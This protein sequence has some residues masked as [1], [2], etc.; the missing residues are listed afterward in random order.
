MVKTIGFCPVMEL[1]K[2]SIHSVCSLLNK[3][4]R[5][6]RHLLLFSVF[7]F[8]LINHIVTQLSLSILHFLVSLLHYLMEDPFV[9]KNLWFGLCST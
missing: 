1:G 4:L 8:Q 2:G 3:Q 7:M 6:F 9:I 5:P